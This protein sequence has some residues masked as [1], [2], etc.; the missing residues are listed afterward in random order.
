MAEGTGDNFFIVKDNVI[1]TPEGR[2]ILRGISRD[3]VFELANQLGM[4]YVE[5][6]IETY[7]VLNADEAFMT[8]TPFCILPVMRLNGQTIGPAGAGGMG[9]VT[10]LLITAWSQN[11][12]VDIIAQIQKYEREAEAEGRGAAPTPY[13]FAPQAEEA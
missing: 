2:N 8:G 7:D 1:I 10:K 5:K 9:S 12:G 11:V 4:Q 3:Y 6:N 13:Q